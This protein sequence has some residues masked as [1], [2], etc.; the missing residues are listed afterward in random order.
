MVGIERFYSG[1]IYTMLALKMG[2]KCLVQDFIDELN[3]SDKKK[4][5]RLLTRSADNGLFTN[6][7]KFRKIKNEN[8]WEFKSAQVRIFCF[9]DKGKIIILSHGFVKKSAKT[10]KNQ[11]EKAKKMLRDYQQWIESK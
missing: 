6:E 3:E 4:T 7:E 9:F 10:P 5:L 11:I 2:G 1:K 8:L